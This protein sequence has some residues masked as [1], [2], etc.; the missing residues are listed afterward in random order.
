MEEEGQAVQTAPRGRWV[1]RH[2]VSTGAQSARRLLRLRRSVPRRQQPRIASANWSQILNPYPPVHHLSPCCMSLSSDEENGEPKNA[3]FQSFKK[4]R[5]QNLRAC[6]RCRQKKIRCKFSKSL[7]HSSPKFSSG[8]G[9]QTPGS[10]CSHCVVSESTCVFTETTKKRG[11]PKRYVDSLESRLEKMEG[12]LSRLYPDGDFSQE[13]DLEPWTRSYKPAEPERSKATNISPDSSSDT[14]SNTHALPGIPALPPG[15]DSETDDEDTDHEYDLTQ[16]EMVKHL[17]QICINPNHRRFYGKSSG[18]RLLR[19]ALDLKSEVS[20]TVP[21]TMRDALSRGERRPDFWLLHPWERERFAPQ[22]ITYVFPEPD[23]LASLVELYFQYIAPLI[24]LLHRPTFMQGLVEGRHLVDAGF[25]GIVLLVCGTASRYSDDPR[26]LLDEANGHFH[27]AGWKYFNQVPLVGTSVLSA[28]GLHDLQITALAVL[29]LHGCSPP[30]AC[31]SLCGIGLRLAQDVGAHRR[32][33][34]NAVPTVEDE[35]WK[36]AFW[37]LYML[38]I[39]MSS[40]LGRPCAI[41]EE[42]Y[43]VDLP[44]DCDDEYWENDDPSLAFKQPAGKTSTMAYFLN[45]IKVN[46]VHAYALRTIYSINKSKVAKGQ[47]GEQ[48]EQHVVAD[49]DSALNNWLDAVPDHLR[50]DPT[51]ENIT[52]FLQS[53]ALH[54]SYYFVQITIHRPFIPSSRKPSCLSFPSLAICANA[55][56]ACSHVADAQRRRMPNATSPNFQLPSFISGVILLL[57]LWGAK[58]SGVHLDASREMQ[59]VQKCMLLLESAESRWPVAGRLRDLLFDL[60][61]VGELP[62]SQIVSIPSLKRER[63]DREDEDL[64]QPSA[65]TPG[66]YPASTPSASHGRQSTR[67]PSSDIPEASSPQQISQRAVA[68]SRRVLSNDAHS[69]NVMSTFGPPVPQPRAEPFTVTS[70]AGSYAS[71]GY[72]STFHSPSPAD[73]SGGLAAAVPVHDHTA[74]AYP[75]IQ[76]T[77]DHLNTQST[78]AGVY[79]FTQQN[80]TAADFMQ[81]MAPSKDQPALDVSGLQMAFASSPPYTESPQVS[82]PPPSNGSFNMLGAFAGDDLGYSQ[83]HMGLPVQDNRVLGFMAPTQDG[84]VGVDSDTMMMWS[85]LPASLESEDWDTYLSNMIGFVN[86]QPSRSSGARY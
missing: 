31:W 32:R 51:R 23:L 10:K 45:L 38:D 18:I 19:E 22:P 79:G 7:V 60:T 44:A 69:S 47:G 66:S 36:R 26:V 39:W 62:Q 4:R 25:A 13:I 83:M 27:S 16:A 46:L 55:A 53:A 11:P 12:L 54:A 2:H 5:V 61:H 33:A 35:L 3:Q 57:S 81:G 15:D 30:Q 41:S 52:H 64:S 65:S 50:W 58:R 82:A 34:Y 29:F 77:S 72:N 85:N 9:T 63:S 40:Y 20:G 86:P 78:Q 48:W 68:G 80:F 28:P 84:Q 37:V 17:R 70:P 24:P 56:R 67:S 76:P 71:N 14:S 49:L 74:S 73:E 75:H 8:D 1:P 59:D 43:D 21:I 6:D 42:T